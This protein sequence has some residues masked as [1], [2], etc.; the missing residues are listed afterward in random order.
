ML[1][2]KRYLITL[3][4]SQK[5]DLSILSDTP[6]EHT[7]IVKNAMD[8]LKTAIDN[9]KIVDILKINPYEKITPFNLWFKNQNY[10]IKNI[11]ENRQNMR[12][13]LY[14]ERIL[15]PLVANNI[16]L[17][18]PIEKIIP[19]MTLYQP[20]YPEMFYNIWEFLQLKYLRSE[21]KSFLSITNERS[22]GSIE[23]IMYYHEKYQNSHQ[24]NTYDIWLAKKPYYNVKY[25]NYNCQ[26]PSI[27][28]LGQAYKHR[29]IKN[30]GNLTNYDFINIDVIG[31]FDKKGYWINEEE[32]L[33]ATLFYLLHSL[34]RLNDTGSILIKMMLIGRPSWES[35][36]DFVNNYFTEHKFYRPTTTN[37]YNPEIYLFADKFDKHKY[38]KTFYKDFM[39]NLYPNLT[40]KV[41]YLQYKSDKISKL[42]KSYYAMIKDWY[43]ILKEGGKSSNA[44][45][46]L[47][48]KFHLAVDLQQIKSL[49]PTFCT[50]SSVFQIKTKIVEYKIKLVSSAGLYNNSIYKKLIQKRGILGSCKRVMDTKP[51]TVFTNKIVYSTYLLNWEQLSK[52]VDVLDGLKSVVRKTYKGEMVTNAWLKFYELISSIFVDLIPQTENIKT[53]HLCEAPGAFISALNHYASNKNQKLD[54][55][56]QT[57]SPDASNALDDYFG[58]IDRYPDKWLFGPNQTGDITDSNVIKSYASDP[59]LKNIDFM[60]ADAGLSCHPRDLNEQESYLSKINMGQIICIL[61]CL[62]IGKSALFKTFLP[63]AEPLTISMMY[64][65]TYHFGEVFITKPMASHDVNSEV[66]VVLKNYKG[67]DQTIL[68]VLYEMLDD[69]SINSKTLLCGGVDKL[70]FD[71]YIEA[72]TKLIDRQIQSLE[73]HYYYYYHLDEIV[74]NTEWYENREKAV[75]MWLKENPIYPLEKFLL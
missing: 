6:L 34:N 12:I 42:H 22:L 74:Q 17:L 75:N 33:Q 11:F 68:N 24:D 73:T 29:F 28:Y 66:Y 57:L 8:I 65:L 40:Y 67:I 15:T 39:E 46:N 3:F 30:T 36:I 53:F 59:N 4:K 41:S 44:S 71:T 7:I 38:Q 49:K 48:E 43:N 52:H 64:L 69:K 70:F 54:W 5:M 13:R 26:R 47:I 21:I 14:N 20:F 2:I 1:R 35:V 50:Q 31:L 61:A 25:G 62:P 10:Q 9:K 72:T 23:S 56:A 58:L 19:E 60:S 32:E 55:Y 51:S 63:M 45:E 37:I 16:N 18:A 27:N